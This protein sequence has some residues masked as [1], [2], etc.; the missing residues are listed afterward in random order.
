MNIESTLLHL[1]LIEKMIKNRY[2]LNSNNLN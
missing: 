1:E 2:T